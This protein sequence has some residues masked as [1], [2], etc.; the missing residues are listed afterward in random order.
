MTGP[1]Y[2]ATGARAVAAQTIGTAI[3]GS[4]TALPAETLHAAR[5][6]QAPASLTNL[7][8][9][10]LCLGR[11][12]ALT[13]LRDTFAEANGTAITQTSAVHGL[14]GIGKSTLALSYAHR[15]RQ[16]YAL[17]W[18]INAE[19]SAHIEQSVGDLALRLVPAWAGG[20][21]HDERAAWALTWLQ[22]H[23]GWLLIFDNVEDPSDLAPYLGALNG[24]HHLITS[25]RATGWPRTIRTHPLG[26][27]DADKSADLICTY[28]FAGSV[29]TPREHQDARALAAELGYLP[30][31]LEQA[32]A[33]LRQNPNITINAYRQRLSAKLDKAA[34]GIDAERTIARI[35]TQTI[36]A[37]T[38]R[39][40][41]SVHVLHTLAWLAP[42]KVSV[43][44]LETPDA[45][46]DDLHE[47][48]GLLNAYSMAT[49]D[50]HTVSVHRLLQAVLR[51]TAPAEPDGSPAGRHAAEEVIVRVLDAPT[52][53]ADMAW[54][55][56]MPHLIAL[57]TTRPAGHS[58]DRAA[59][60]YNVAAQ[61]LHIQGRYVRATPLLAAVVAQCEQV[62]GD[63]HPN[64]LTSRNNLAL[65]Y[66]QAGD[67]AR[68][69]P[70][71]ESVLADRERLLG[72]IHP[73]TLSS[74]N[75]LANAYRAAGDTDRSMALYEA[76]LPQCVQVLGDTHP[77]TLVTRNNL[78]N[79]YASAGNLDLAIPLYETVLAQCE[80]ALG[81]THPTTLISRTSL[82][83]V[84]A[85]AGDLDLAIPLHKTVLAQFEQVLGDTHPNTITSRDSLA[86]AYALAGDS[87]LSIPLFESVLA[88]RENVLG[89]IHPDTLS[90]RD[91]LA[92][93]YASMGDLERS[94]P[95]LRTV[96]TQREDLLGDTHPDTLS[97][98]NYLAIAYA[99]MGDL[100]RSLPLLRT[101]LTQYESLLG[102]T[103]PDTLSIRN[104]LDALISTGR[105]PGVLS[106]PDTQ[107]SDRHRIAR[108]PD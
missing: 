105:S 26:A 78:A 106:S 33:Y 35:W 29:I 12:D 100:D 4:V 32:G 107:L 44:L 79:T 7:P 43:S 90:S 59:D 108:Q 62:L 64:T 86:D 41:Q 19:S 99:S 96:L 9:F 27:L 91:S 85:A 84:Y 80:Q 42:D 87:N 21:S 49:V 63:I 30:L 17:I 73:D 51:A 13:C 104:Y 82:A 103:H 101:V 52:P 92:A 10:P 39:N 97:S 22:W 89:D 23:P 28:A 71:H 83:G 94:L 18:W 2:D 36:K 5:D 67:L 24:G 102:G 3:T 98:R 53:G 81:D 60:R 58:G 74:R 66:R 1:H 70:L 47:A 77:H 48:L 72:D 20:A 40:P 45:D 8:P 55:T 61:H 76:V 15:F 31:A 50:R 93:A 75:N 57:A 11:E 25:R 38:A 37:L 65:A 34:V 95:L 46:N 88:Q 54:D 16:D 14:G 6:I 69:V 56:V 68:A